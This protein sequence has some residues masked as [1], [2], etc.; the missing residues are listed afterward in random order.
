MS[1]NID[2]PVA[3]TFVFKMSGTKLLFR[4]FLDFLNCDFFYINEGER[5]RQSE[6]GREREIGE[7]D[8]I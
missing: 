8:R 3:M 2:L 7:R 5:V 6:G 1:I 4:Y